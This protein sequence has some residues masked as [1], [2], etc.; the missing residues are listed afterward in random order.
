M[1][2]LEP[3]CLLLSFSPTACPV[4]NSGYIHRIR[5]SCKLKPD[6]IVDLDSK[7]QKPKKEQLTKSQKRRMWDRGGLESEER[8]RYGMGV[9]AYKHFMGNIDIILTCI[10]YSGAG[11]GSTSSGISPKLAGN[12]RARDS[13]SYTFFCMTTNYMIKWTQIAV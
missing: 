2:W 7:S 12:Q 11:I 6:S 5:I 8:P 3:V 1:A 10:H 4:G 13:I 9:K